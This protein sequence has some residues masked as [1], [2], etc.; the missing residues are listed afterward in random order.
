MR[1][2]MPHSTEALDM[3]TRPLPP[4]SLGD[5]VILQNQRGSHPKKWDKSG[6]VVEL[7]NYHQNWEKVDGSGRPY[8]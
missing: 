8:R 7:G 3:H 5:K 6:I 4:L 2:R 1:T